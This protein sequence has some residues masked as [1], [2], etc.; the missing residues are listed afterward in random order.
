MVHDLWQLNPP[1]SIPLEAGNV[2]VFQYDDGPSGICGQSMDVT[3][4]YMV[5]RWFPNEDAFQAQKQELSQR[6]GKNHR[7]HVVAI[8]EG[9]TCHAF[10]EVNSAEKEAGQ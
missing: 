1:M 10:V 3:C 2:L 9:G 8:G 5:I 4:P 6:R 7:C